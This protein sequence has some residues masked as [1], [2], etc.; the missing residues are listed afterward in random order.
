VCDDDILCLVAAPHPFSFK[1]PECHSFTGNSSPPSPCRRHLFLCSI[2]TSCSYLETVQ[3]VVA[4]PPS[5][6]GRSC[7][8]LEHVLTVCRR[9]VDVADACV[10]ACE[11]GRSWS[12]T[13]AAVEQTPEEV[14][15]LHALP[16]PALRSIGRTYRGK[17]ELPYKLTSEQPNG[18]NRRASLFSIDDLAL[19]QRHT[20][21][22]RESFPAGLR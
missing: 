9:V 12:R 22:P 17:A 18:A 3:G 7:F 4:K 21:S 20:H 11:S 6:Y 13:P 10:R 16:C 14:T 2:V 1:E 19:A 5:L 8:G 15:T